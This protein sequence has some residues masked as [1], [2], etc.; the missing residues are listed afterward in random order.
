M[1]T[2]FLNLPLYTVRLYLKGL[3]RRR[4]FGMAICWILA[5]GGAFNVFLL[6]NNYESTAVIYVDTNTL[7]GPLLKG[8][9]IEGNAGQQTQVVRETLLNNPN[10]RQV[11]RAADLDFSVNTEAE[12]E[13]LI[14]SIRSRVTVRSQGPGSFRI[15]FRD[16]DPEIAK[17]VVQGLLAVFVENN[18]GQN[19]DAMQSARSFIEQQVEEY[20]KKLTESERRLAAFRA[21][22]GMVLGATNF[23][24]RMSDARQRVEDTKYEIADAITRRD[25]LRARNIADLQA[26]L[27]TLLLQY[28]DSHPD[29]IAAR[30]QLEVMSDQ[31]QKG[32]GGTGS[33]QPDGSGPTSAN[34]MVQELQ[35]RLFDADTQIKQAQRRLAQAERDLELLTEYIEIAPELDAELADMTRQH[36]VIRSN[37]EQLL[38][39]REAARISQALDSETDAVQ[40][41]VVEPPEAPATPSGP[42]RPLLLAGVLFAAIGI[43]GTAAFMRFQ[44]EQK[45]Y[46][47]EHIEAALKV[48][49]VGT[50][51]RVDNFR[52]GMKRSMSSLGFLV[53]SGCF[54]VIF[55]GLFLFLS[56]NP[57]SVAKRV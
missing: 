13:R 48:P 46:D 28:T 45:F 25:Q 27:S 38:A 57:F 3:W 5:V 24:T 30:R 51:T 16:R 42:D 26:Q 14:G 7:L 34:P 32:G 54:V 53:V 1:H 29:V 39:R 36:Q 19:Q 22:Y 23:A 21:K 37:Y 49:V 8:L 18:L 6:P 9:A 52:D 50:I 40:F 11:A 56:Y 41:R 31:Y 44:L 10:L 35:V 33:L 55:L 47:P 12:M 20:E 15:R 2:S 43:G 17:R 4:W